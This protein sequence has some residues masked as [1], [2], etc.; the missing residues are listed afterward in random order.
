MTASPNFLQSKILI[1]LFGLVLL[2]CFLYVQHLH[3]NGLGA[4]L[5][6]DNAGKL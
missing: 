6:F 2:H 3:L 4:E 5:D 1:Q